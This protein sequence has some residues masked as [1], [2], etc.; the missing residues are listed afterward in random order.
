MV[1]EGN[2]YEIFSR[3]KVP[4]EI[5]FFVR[6]DGRNFHR[7]TEETNF[8]KPYDREFAEIMVESAKSLFKNNLNPIL[9]YVFSD[10]INVLFLESPFNGRIEKIDSIVASLLSSAFSLELY[11]RRNI[12]K[13]ISFDAR[14]IPIPNKRILEY[15]AWRQ[16]ECWRNHINSYAFYT[17]VEKGF[18]R[19][20]AAKMLKGLKS[21]ELHDLVFKEKGINLA[22]TPTWQRRGILLYFEEYLKEGINKL[23]GERV[24]T[25][26]RKLVENW[27]LPIFNSPEGENLISKII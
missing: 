1:F 27:E 9:A 19:E 20:D 24:L 22:K 4:Y 10:E 13:T 26:R 21:A 12:E 3:I 7:L 14:V 2:K 8:K 5:P 25:V 18:S 23:T 17:L 6:C 15:L 11:L 16:L